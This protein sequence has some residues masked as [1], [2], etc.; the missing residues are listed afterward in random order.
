VTL[1]IVTAMEENPACVA[2]LGA[3]NRWPERSGAPLE[4]YLTLW[5]ESCVE[6]G[7]TRS[8]PARLGRLLYN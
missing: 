8:L 3:L 7:A 4:T 6:I 2:D 1:A 5:G